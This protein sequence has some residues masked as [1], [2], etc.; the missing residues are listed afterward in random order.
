MTIKELLNYG[1][2]NL[3]NNNIE[4]PV[5]KARIILGFVINKPKEYIITHDKEEVI[6]QYI[7][8]YKVAVNKMC[9]G[10]PIQYITNKQEFM[11]LNFYV[12]ENVL[13][14]QNDTEILVEEVMNLCKDFE[15]VVVL[16][17]CTGSGAIGVS[18]AK[19]VE[20]SVVYA[21]DI[22]SKALQIAKLNSKNNM[23]STKMNFIESN[24]FEKIENIKFD[25][26]VTNPPYIE[27]D[28]IKELDIEVQH[29]PK[30]ALDGGEDGLD[31]YK[32]IIENADKYL[33]KD[34]YL[35]LEIG[36]NQKEAVVNL[37][38][39]TNKYKDIYSKQDLA[40]NDRIIVAKKVN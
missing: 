23:V 32:N 24:L 28:T 20:K 4:N 10:I 25:I 35:A 7:N 1:I 6:I 39:N 11:K 9:N 34:G 16:D 37:I 5:M 18:I 19:Y 31:F 29:E 40:G 33:K 14:P 13:I 26:I 3:R 38:E 8:N 2:K 36:Y 12:D 21:S 22:S 27:T 30:I 17:L 15:K